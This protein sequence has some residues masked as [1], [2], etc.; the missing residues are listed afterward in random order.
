M[1]YT[2]KLIGDHRLFMKSLI[3]RKE[4]NRN[5]FVEMIN[6]LSNQYNLYATVIGLL[7]PHFPTRQVVFNML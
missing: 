3:S 6:Q 1:H 5:E 7:E 4:Y 2:V